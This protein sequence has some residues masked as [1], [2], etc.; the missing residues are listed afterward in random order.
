MEEISQR[1]IQCIHKL[2]LDT[3][4]L[5]FVVELHFFRNRVDFSKWKKLKPKVCNTHNFSVTW[6]E[7][8][9]SVVMQHRFCQASLFS[10][11]FFWTFYC[12]QTDVSPHFPRLNVCHWIVLSP[13]CV[14]PA[15]R[16]H[17][18][19]SP[20][21]GG[22]LDLIPPWTR[23]LLKILFYY[24]SCWKVSAQMINALD[25]V[26]SRRLE[27]SLALRITLHVTFFFPV[28]PWT[29]FFSEALKHFSLQFLCRKWR[30]TDWS[31]VSTGTGFPS[32]SVTV[33][34][35][36]CKAGM[37]LRIKVNHALQ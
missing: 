17:P 30:Q 11:F 7:K 14:A 23:H 36:S 13:Q 21:P 3:K 35:C 25:I 27:H 12:T 29:F 15:T 31:P 37:K 1:V 9:Q 4:S 10:F 2:S 5:P 32:T 34:T 28:V 22:R 20:S 26:E 33:K 19:L 18:S 8:A 16:C 6:K 24:F